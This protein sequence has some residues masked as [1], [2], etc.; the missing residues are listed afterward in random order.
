MK[1]KSKQANERPNNKPRFL[2][3]TTESTKAQ[4]QH[5]SRLPPLLRPQVRS[6]AATHTHNTA[7][8]Q[9]H[10]CFRRLHLIHR[11]KT[12]TSCSP[13]GPVPP[14]FVCANFV[15]FANMEMVMCVRCVWAFGLIWFLRSVLCSGSQAPFSSC[16]LGTCTRGGLRNIYS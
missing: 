5:S 7:Q 12:T 1:I 13:G 6:S 10:N 16:S 15:P 9:P 11:G 8:T 2:P 3:H 4:S 14:K